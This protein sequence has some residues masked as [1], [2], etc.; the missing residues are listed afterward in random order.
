MENHTRTKVSH[1]DV[2]LARTQVSVNMRRLGLLL[3]SNR[4]VLDSY[5]KNKNRVWSLY[6]QAS[7]DATERS[8]TGLLPGDGYLLGNTTKEALRAL[9]IVNAGLLDRVESEG[10][11]VGVGN[12]KARAQRAI[13]ERRRAAAEN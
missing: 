12:L 7:E 3:D 4:I 11:E 13:M 2:E 5:Q 1:V 6:F 8:R 10:A 9:E